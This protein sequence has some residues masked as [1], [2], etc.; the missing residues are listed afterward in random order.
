M[1]AERAELAELVAMAARGRVAPAELEPSTPLLKGGVAL[2]SVEVL[3]LVVSL[4]ERYGIELRPDELAHHLHTFERLEAV[5]S[6]RR[7]R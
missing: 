6:A 5:V 4:E 1:S 7:G 3:E 2:D